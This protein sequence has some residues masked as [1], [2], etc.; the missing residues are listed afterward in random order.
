MKVYGSLRKSESCDYLI[1][2][3]L[4]T[5]DIAYNILDFKRRA[6][7]SMKSRLTGIDQIQDLIFSHE[8]NIFNTIVHRLKYGGL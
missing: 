8:E 1:I 7:P 6:A 2:K 4:P 3:Q 5:Q